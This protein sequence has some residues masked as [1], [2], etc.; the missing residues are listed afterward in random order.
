MAIM[1]WIS[2]EWQGQPLIWS[3]I[4]RQVMIRTVMAGISYL[5]SLC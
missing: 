3:P 5:A 4:I 1:W 2:D